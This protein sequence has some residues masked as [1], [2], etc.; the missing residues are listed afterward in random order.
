MRSPW[1][2]FFWGGGGL[3]FSLNP[4]NNTTNED[5]GDDISNK[6]GNAIDS[7]ILY[8]LCLLLLSFSTFML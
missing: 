7:V 6:F 4:D 3:N 5:I 8:T 1:I 2:F